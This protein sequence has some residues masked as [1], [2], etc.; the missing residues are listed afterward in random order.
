MQEK[1]VRIAQIAGLTPGLPASRER[2]Q[3]LN[4]YRNTRLKT[5]CAPLGAQQQHIPFAPKGASE[6]HPQLRFYKHSAPNGA[7]PEVAV[8]GESKA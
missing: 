1:S 3:A 5:I 2:H 4:V 6:I 8:S 7:C